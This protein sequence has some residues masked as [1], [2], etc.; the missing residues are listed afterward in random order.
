M[1]PGMHHYRSQIGLHAFAVDGST[2]LA[3]AYLKEHGAG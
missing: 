2:C 1:E 3:A